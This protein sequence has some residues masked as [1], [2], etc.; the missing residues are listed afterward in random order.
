[1]ENR[2]LTLRERLVEALALAAEVDRRARLVRILGLGLHADGRVRLGAPDDWISRW[3]Y[4]FIVGDEDGESL[5]YITVLYLSPDG[6]RVDPH[7]GNVSE[8][9]FFDDEVID[10]LHDS[11]RLVKAFNRRFCSHPMAGGE[12]DVLLITMRRM[13]DP[14]AVMYNGNGDQMRLDPV[15]LEPR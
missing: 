3:E 6:P 11:D 4:A 9:E 5:G 14:I 7:A 13:L 1:M 12:D 15:S 10:G 2:A 8:T